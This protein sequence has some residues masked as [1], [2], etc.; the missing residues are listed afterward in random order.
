MVPDIVLSK[1]SNS[2]NFFSMFDI[3]QH[4]KKES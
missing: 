2:V 1:M 4:L 3:T